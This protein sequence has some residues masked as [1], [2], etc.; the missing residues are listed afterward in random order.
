MRMNQRNLNLLFYD[1]RDVVF[2]ESIFP[3]RVDD[4]DDAVHK[5]DPFDDADAEYI[6][7]DVDVDPPVVERAEETVDAGRET[8]A[9]EVGARVVINSEKYSSSPSDPVPSSASGAPYSLTHFIS[10]DKF[11]VRQRSFVAAIDGNVEPRSFREAMKDSRWCDAMNHEI[12]ALIRNGTWQI[13]GLSKSKI[14]IGNKWI[15]KVKLKANGSVERFKARLMVL[16]N[17]QEE[18]IDFF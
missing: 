3:Y 4:V 12:E 14:A 1:F 9:P 18:G 7:T 5:H 15:Y 11:Y 6:L 10:S 8:A 16:G 2:D 13:V 17:T